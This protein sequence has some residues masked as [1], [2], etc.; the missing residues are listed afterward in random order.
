MANGIG[1]LIALVAAM[2]AVVL[3]AWLFT[4]LTTNMDE[5]A[6]I[7]EG[8]RAVSVLM[9]GVLISVA[10]LTSTAVERIVEAVNNAMF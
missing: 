1:L 2:I 3:A 4:R 10:L 7:T 8:N 9:A 6:E 5:W